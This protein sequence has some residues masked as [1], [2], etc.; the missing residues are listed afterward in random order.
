MEFDAA[1][2]ARRRR[3]VAGRLLGTAAALAA[4]AAALSLFLYRHPPSALIIVAFAVVILGALWLS[5]V[6]Y[7]IALAVAVVLLAAVRFE[8][9]PADV[10][11]AVLIIVGAITSRFRLR[12]VIPGAVLLVGAY[13]ALNLVSAVGVADPQRAVSFF[14]ITF[15]VACFGLWLA[16]Y[17]TSSAIARRITRCYVAAAVVSALV[18]TLALLVPFP[19]HDLFTRIGRAEGLFKDPNVFGPFLVPAALIV[20]EEILTPR[21][22]R[23]GA[24]PRRCC[25]SCSALGVLFSYSRAA[26]LN[27]VVGLVVV[28]VIV[29]FRRGGG[30]SAA[31]ALAVVLV[32]RRLG[33][34]GRGLLGLVVV[35]RAAREGAPEL[36]Q[37]PVQGRS[38]RASRGRCRARSGSARGSTSGGPTSRRTASMPARS[39]RKGCPAC[40]RS[41]R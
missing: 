24:R 8:P 13:L 29:S 2:S 20:L 1:P 9:A 17:V 7:D 18:S 21:L 5:I 30:K 35:P 16:A 36:R 39:P 32:A 10:V 14:A 38:P 31:R 15:Y 22:L 26:W 12:R 40:S 37:R 28:L 3:A 4:F 41:S 25:S 23:A 27:L 19:G 33:R 11:F 6:A 34:G